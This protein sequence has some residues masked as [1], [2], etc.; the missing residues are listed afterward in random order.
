[1]RLEWNHPALLLLVTMASPLEANH[2]FD[3]QLSLSPMGRDCILECENNGF[4][5]FVADTVNQLQ[6]IAQSG[7]LIQRCRCPPGWGGVVCE[8]PQKIVFP[9]KPVNILA[10]PAMNLSSPPLPGSP[11]LIP[12]RCIINGAVIVVL[13]IASIPTLPARCV[14]RAT[15]NTAILIPTIPIV[16]CTFV[17]MEASVGSTFWR[18]KNSREIWTFGNNT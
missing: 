13:P 5:E 17:P 11:H 7:G 8:I 2:N 12:F 18:P 3:D 16:P 6:K 14:A 1:M 10:V 9:T 15:R 4:C